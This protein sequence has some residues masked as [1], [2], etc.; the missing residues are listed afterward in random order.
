LESGARAGSIPR[1][2][3]NEALARSACLVAKCPGWRAEAPGVYIYKG[4][5]SASRPAVLPAASKERR[6]S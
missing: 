5:V 4:A 6:L 1:R 2:I 3:L